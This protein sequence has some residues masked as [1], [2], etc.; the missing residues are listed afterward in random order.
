MFPERSVRV[1]TEG[2]NENI[3]HIFDLRVHVIAKCG[4]GSKEIAG[5]WQNKSL[6]QT[7]VCRVLLKCKVSYRKILS[8][9][10][11]CFLKNIC[12]HYLNFVLWVNYCFLTS[13]WLAHYQLSWNVYCYL[14]VIWLVNF[15]YGGP[16]HSTC[17]VHLLLM[18][19]LSKIQC[20]NNWPNRLRCQ[21]WLLKLSQASQGQWKKISSPKTMRLGP[22]IKWLQMLTSICHRPLRFNDVVF[23]AP[24]PHKFTALHM[25]VK[26]DKNGI[27][28][29]LLS[30]KDVNINACDEVSL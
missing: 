16:G 11:L 8:G 5:R 13:C 29:L 2:E 4:N 1:S 7:Y 6:C 25:A 28:Q 10:T 17:T 24:Q 14:P 12:Y 9:E 23:F 18:F 19:A 30:Q 20:T 21:C 3:R 27:I 22:A 26:Q 15:V